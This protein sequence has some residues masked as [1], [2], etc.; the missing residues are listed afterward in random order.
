MEGPINYRD[1]YKSFGKKVDIVRDKAPYI[2][3]ST[4]YAFYDEKIDNIEKACRLFERA[5]LVI[6]AADNLR[7]DFFI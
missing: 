1:H 6:S 4:Q 3:P 5:D 7:P 2:S